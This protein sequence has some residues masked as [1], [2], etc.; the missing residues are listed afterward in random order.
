M[1]RGGSEGAEQA[2]GVKRLAEEVTLILIA[3][4]FVAIVENFFLVFYNKTKQLW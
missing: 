4:L 2:E 1:L 3:S